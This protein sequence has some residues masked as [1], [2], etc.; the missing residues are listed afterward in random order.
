MINRD[1]H[2]ITEIIDIRRSYKSRFLCKFENER[3]TKPMEKIIGLNRI[4]ILFFIV[5]MASMFSTS[6]AAAQIRDTVYFNAKWKKTDRDGKH[7]YRVVHHE[8]TTE[9]I[10]VQDFYPNGIQQME[11]WY[12]SLDP[13][14]RNGD[15]TW[16]H[17]DGKKHR[18]TTFDNGT[19]IEIT[20]WD[21]DGKITRQQV[22]VKTVSYLNGEPVYDRRALEKPPI[23]NRGKSSFSEY[24]TRHLIYP[25]ETEGMTGKV[26]VRFVVDKKGRTRDAE[27]VQSV[28]KAFDKAALDF[29]KSLPRWT[30][31]ALK[32]KSVN[33]KMEVPVNFQ[34]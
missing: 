33:I 5:I 11:G 7:F 16:W 14:V 30:P 31:G 2:Y 4:F 27:V 8:D 21:N 1:F 26:I 6:Q 13:E 3:L 22:A 34:P 28:N 29:V 24:A 10:R 9:S 17:E 32:G 18:Q 15:F 20:E 25:T 12:S 23:F 19:P